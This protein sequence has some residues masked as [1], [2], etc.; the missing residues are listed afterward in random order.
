MS[1]NTFE[2]QSTPPKV[3][4]LTTVDGRT[5][6]LR[7]ARIRARAEG[8]LAF[9][10]LTQEYANPY[11][12]PLE[13]IYSLP[14]PAD[15]AVLG[16]TVHVGDRIIRGEIQPR[17]KAEEE[18]RKAIYEGRTA[19]LLEQDREDTFQQRLGN[20]PARTDARIEIEIL[21]P[22]AFLAAIGSDAP[23]WEYRFPT[24]TGVRY[25]GG[26]GR[27]PDSGR[28]DADRDGD[29]GIP[30]RVALDLTIA[31]STAR[32]GLASSRTHDI[33]AEAGEAGV[34]VRL[35]ASSRLDRDLAIRW[36]ASV[37][38]VGVRVVEGG[39]LAG[40]DGRYALL[41]ITPPETPKA[42]YRRD[43]TV[44]IDTSGSMM[45]DPIRLAKRV[46][47]RLLESLEPRDRFEV[48]AF[49]E[50]PNRLT[51]GLIDASSKHVST[52][53]R[54]MEELE[55]GGA[56]EMSRAM[57]EALRP[58]RDDAQRQVVLVTDGQIGF[59]REVI[60]TLTSGKQTIARVHVVGVGSAANRSLTH[61]VARAGR[62]VELHTCDDSTADEAAARLI[63]ASAS[64]VLVDVTVGGPAVRA[65][66][67]KNPR[68]VFAA[69]PL[70]MTLELEPPG[71]T[72]EVAA[73]LA[74][75]KERW[76]WRMEV[77]A[78]GIART[79]LPLGAHHGREIIADLESD[80]ALNAWHAI[81]FPPRPG[82]NPDKE[83]EAV[84]MRHKIVSRRTS[85]VAIA[86]EV[87]V[88]PLAPRRRERLAVE[89][90]AGVSAEGVGLERSYPRMAGLMQPTAS[91]SRGL[92]GREIAMDASTPES[93]D[94]P[95]LVRGGRWFR[96]GAFSDMGREVH[97]GF[98]A[99]IDITGPEAVIEFE[100]QFDGFTLPT[101]DLRIKVAGEE[102]GKA[103]VVEEKSTA[104]GP[105]AK[106][107][108]VRLAFRLEDGFPW[109]AGEFLTVSW[110]TSDGQAFELMT[111]IPTETG[112]PQ[113]P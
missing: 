65:S 63:T 29:G 69:Q 78:A 15:G 14:L 34:H 46:V 67:P 39:G 103:R 35:A 26:A 91:L 17:E 92:R 7:A 4:T 111:G 59:E 36:A 11:D 25:Q 104:R 75:S 31:D 112:Q 74:G 44:L 113:N 100:V 86:E 54:R 52:C 110:E 97:F 6:P 10:T 70:V 55:A 108:L 84:A 101:G 109:P 81:T 23:Q 89:L 94:W 51:R 50:K 96:K 20:I 57:A 33:L 77:P 68:D 79:P 5:Y 18:Y 8:G 102:V 30:A 62:G 61:G 21:Q 82:S 43:L 98:A 2:A 56:T 40:D 85:L 73:R 105:H 28:L 66:A 87:S 106:G 37:A 45:G 88:D 71:G 13:V 16:Y 24:V 3:A 99:L 64:P 1:P 19:G 27:V 32:A 47:T 22:L 58:Q 41:T 107:L 42:C 80:S 49:A 12:Q 72:L 95:K 76:L 9:T 53:V 93:L 48:L 90:P 60:A 38:E 83:I